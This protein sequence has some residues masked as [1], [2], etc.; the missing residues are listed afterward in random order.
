MF[1]ICL[2]PQKPVRPCPCY[3]GSQLVDNLCYPRYYRTVE[4]YGSCSSKDSAGGGLGST[5][6][7]ASQGKYGGEESEDLQTSIKIP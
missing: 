6:V 3:F 5:R 2:G 7:R 4:K 1:Y